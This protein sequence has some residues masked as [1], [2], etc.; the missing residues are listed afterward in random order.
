MNDSCG[1]AKYPKADRTKNRTVPSG[2]AKRQ[3]L[4]RLWRDANGGE[5]EEEAT[6]GRK[7][8]VYELVVEVV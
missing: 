1:I 4:P 5:G 2:S 6:L 3:D 8:F 7:L